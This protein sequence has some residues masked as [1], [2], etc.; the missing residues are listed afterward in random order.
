MAV[1]TDGGAPV[2][3]TNWPITNTSYYPFGGAIALAL[4]LTLRDR[5]DSRVTL[6]DFMRAMWRVHG[7]PGGGREGDVDHPYMLADAEARL[8]EVSGDAPFAAGFFN[9]FIRG[10]DVADYATLLARAGF[11]LRPRSP[12]RP[13]WGDQA[14]GTRRPTADRR[15]GRLHHTGLCRWP[16][17]GRRTPRQVDGAR[18]QFAEDVFAALQRRQ[19]G[20]RIRVT[21]VDWTRTEKTTTVTLAADPHLEVVP[22][23][24]TAAGMTPAQRAFRER[25]LGRR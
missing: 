8:A 16:R 23:D 24:A 21:Y 20:D 18:V 22:V 25:W 10:H 1:F 9:R 5:S 13:W 2:D 4:D 14:R 6:D 12:G 19:P 15:P 3:R 11:A 7:K 17:A